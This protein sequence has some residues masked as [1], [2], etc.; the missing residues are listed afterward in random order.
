MHLK[1]H[2]QKLTAYEIDPRDVALY[3]AE[4]WKNVYDGGTP[5]IKAV[6]NSLSPLKINKDYLLC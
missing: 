2:L 1:V 5:S 3:F 6:Y 4:W